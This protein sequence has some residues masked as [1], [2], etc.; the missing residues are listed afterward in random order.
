MKT[1]LHSYGKLPLPSQPVPN[2]QGEVK[3]LEEF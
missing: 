2:T 3:I 1:L